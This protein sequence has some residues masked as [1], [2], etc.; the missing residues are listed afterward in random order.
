MKE[1]KRDG[2]MGEED[3]GNKLRSGDEPGLAKQK[4][5]STGFSV[6]AQQRCLF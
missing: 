4:A 2:K 5:T 1:E 3:C 6:I